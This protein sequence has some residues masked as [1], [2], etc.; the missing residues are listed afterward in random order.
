MNIAGHEVMVLRLTFVGEMGYELHIPSGSAVA[1]YE[2]LMRGF[3]TLSAQGVKVANSGYRAIDSLSAEKGY[4]HW[5]ADLSN[6]D[7]PQ[8]A[9]IFFT[10]SSKL[11]H[12]N[13]NYIGREVHESQRAS[14]VQRKL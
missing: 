11:K 2:A 12:A 13:T 4:R 6:S 9:N 3:D 7:T 10:I 5:H 14:G 8:E 1:V